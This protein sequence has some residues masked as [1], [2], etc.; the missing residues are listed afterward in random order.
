[1]NKQKKRDRVV[2]GLDLGDRR[3][4]FCVLGR[5]GEVVEEGSL[6][7]ERLALGGL[8]SRYSDA[9]VVMEA[10]CHSPWVS[11]YLKQLGCKVIVSNP[12]KGCELSTSTSAKAIDAMH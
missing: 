12:R 2:I 1:M 7:N 8:I 9:F 11:R 4:R 6:L 3:H 5:S 10:G